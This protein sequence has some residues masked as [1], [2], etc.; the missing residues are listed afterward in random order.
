[1]GRGLE[2]R[3][4]SENLPVAS[5]YSECSRDLEHGVALLFRPA[6][7]DKVSCWLYGCWLCG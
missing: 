2:V 4:E 5:L 3:R 1:M 7:E 6:D